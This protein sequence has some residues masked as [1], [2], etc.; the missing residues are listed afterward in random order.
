MIQ[1][2]I[3]TTDRDAIRLCALHSGKT[4]E[5]VYPGRI[6]GEHSV[7]TA[8]D[9]LMHEMGVDIH[10]VTSIEVAV[11]PGSFM[12]IKIGIITAMTLGLTLSVP[13]N[14]KTVDPAQMHIEPVYSS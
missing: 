5:R 14:G 7:M 6:K 4:F 2:Q 1:L 12:G 9:S 11:G 3:D 13:V 10:D 8:I